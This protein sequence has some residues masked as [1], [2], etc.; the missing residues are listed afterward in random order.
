MK[1]S[2]H[3]NFLMH[4]VIVILINHSTYLSPNLKL[5][6]IDCYVVF[7]IIYYTSIYITHRKTYILISE[8]EVIQEKCH[9]FIFNN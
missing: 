3:S 7:I 2:L 5:K 8:K 1:P 4:I 9:L 6:T